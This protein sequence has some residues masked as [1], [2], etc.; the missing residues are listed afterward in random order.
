MKF[1]LRQGCWTLPTLGTDE[2]GD[3]LIHLTLNRYFVNVSGVGAAELTT[4]RTSAFSTLFPEKSLTEAGAHLFGSTSKRA[5]SWDLP[6]FPE[7]CGDVT[8]VLP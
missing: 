1:T 5:S 6:V 2:G 7:P 4:Q 3:I 8:N